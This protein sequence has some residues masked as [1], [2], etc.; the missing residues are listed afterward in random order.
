MTDPEFWKS[1]SGA[2][3]AATVA[4][5]TLPVSYLWRKVERSAS[6]DDLNKH[7]VEERERTSE[8]RTTFARLF[9]DAK[10]DRQSTDRRFTEM[11]N[12]IHEVHIKVVE[13]LM[14]KR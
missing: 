6:K 13:Q 14:S 11:Q 12:T 5:F 10:E 9:D 2:L 8:M 7:I 4:A 1:I 3:W